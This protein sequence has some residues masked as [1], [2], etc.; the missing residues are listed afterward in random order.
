[1]NNF[2]ISSAGIGTALK[3]SAAAL[4]SANNTL[5]ES[6]ALITAGNTVVQNPEIIGTTAKTI[7]MFLR[8]SKTEAQEAGIETD[9]MAESVSKLRKEILALT[10]V[11]GGAGVD[12]MLDENTY[13]STYQILKEIAEVWD[14]I[15]DVSQA[16]ILEKLGGKRNAN[17]VASI[18]ENFDVA[19]EALRTS[20]DSIGSATEENEK[21]LNSIEGHLNKLKV[22]FEN[23]SQ[24]IINSDLV[25]GAIDFLTN[26]SGL[27]NDIVNNHGLWSIPTALAAS[28]FFNNGKFG[29]STAVDE[30]KT[31]FTILGKT[32]DQWKEL[33]TS[34]KADGG[35][36]LNTFG[37]ALG[38]RIKSLFGYT[39]KADIAMSKKQLTDFNQALVENA[40]QYGLSKSAALSFYQAQIQGNGIL[41]N[42]SDK[43]QSVAL[44]LAEAFSK[45]GELDEATEAGTNAIESF[46]TALSATTTSATIGRLAIN[47]LKEAF[48]SLAPMLIV[49]AISFIVTKVQQAAEEVEKLRAEAIAAS[50]EET[51]IIADV[52]TKLVE[53]N[54][55]Y[56]QSQITKSEY[57]N[58]TEKLVE[59]LHNEGIAVDN[60]INKYEDFGKVLSQD[61]ILKIKDNLPNLLERAQ[62]DVASLVEQITSIYDTKLLNPS[63]F[64]IS[65]K[66]TEVKSIVAA[67][68][69][70]TG[71]ADTSFGL[72]G[73]SII[74]IL[75]GKTL[76]STIA[77][78]N[79]YGVQ[80]DD[81]LIYNE[82]KQY[83]DDLTELRSRLYSAGETNSS[84]YKD[85]E[86]AITELSGVYGDAAK[87]TE[88]YNK[89]VATVL[90]GQYALNNEL[91]KTIE[92]Y[93]KYRSEIL[94][95][96]Y[97]NE[98]F[99]IT[100]ISGSQITDAILTAL[101]ADSSLAKWEQQYQNDQKT[102]ERLNTIYPRMLN[103]EAEK[104]KQYI[105]TLTPEDMGILLSLDDKDIQKG[106]TSVK[107]QIEKAHISL[108]LDLLNTN[109][110]I[111]LKEPL[112]DITK[113]QGKLKP[114]YAEIANQQGKVQL[115]L[116]QS[117]VL[118]DELGS[119]IFDEFE[120]ID[121]RIVLTSSDL[122]D[123]FDKFKRG[124]VENLYDLIKQVEQYLDTLDRAKESGL[125]TE[126]E[127]DKQ[128]L[129]YKQI[130]NTLQ[131]RQEYI[132]QIQLASSN[133]D[134]Y[135][136]VLEYTATL[137]QNL[138]H[139][140]LA[141]KLLGEF[142]ATD[143][144]IADFD[145]QA[146]EMIDA[147]ADN[148]EY[149]KQIQ[150][151]YQI[152][153]NDRSKANAQ[154][155]VDIWKEAYDADVNNFNEYQTIRSNILELYAKDDSAWNEFINANATFVQ[156]LKNQYD[157]DLTN[158]K[159]WAELRDEIIK[160]H[161]GIEIDKVQDESAKAA[162]RQA[163][164]NSVLSKEI[165]TRLRSFLGDSY[166]YEPKDDG[167]AKTDSTKQEKDT[168]DEK[169]KN[170]LKDLK[171][172]NKGTIENEKQF[173]KDWTALNEETYKTTDP[174]KYSENLKEISDYIES[175]DELVTK[176]LGK[177]DKVNSY[178]EN[179]IASR[180]VHLAEARRIN[181]NAYGDPNSLFY[182]LDT[183]EKNAADQ[184]KY[185]ADTL[186]L[187]F[188]RGLVDYQTF[189][190][191]IR[192]IRESA[193]D[194]DGNY[195]LD[196]TFVS[197]YEDRDK[198]FSEQLD[199]LQR[200]NDKSLDD[201]AEY[202]RQWKAL[203]DE[204]YKGTDIT[205]YE[206]NL[207]EIANYERD[208]LDRR[209][210]E[211]L[212][213]AEDYRASLI[214]LWED[215]NAILGEG[216]LNEWLSSAVDNEKAELDRLY[217]E[218]KISA[219]EYFDYVEALWEENQN[220]LGQR[221]QEEWLE[222][223]WK[224]RAE[225]EKTYWEQQKDLAT[226][227]YD[228]EL[229][230]LQDVKDEE[231]KISK[232]EELRLNLI[233]A[234][235]ALEDAKSQRNQLVFH[236]GTFEYM[237]DQEAVMSAQE[238]IA[239]ALKAIKDNE[240]EEQIK[241]LEEQKDEALL[242]YDNIITMLD[243]YINDTKQILT[244]DSEVLAHAEASE[245]G[246]YF[247]RLMNGEITM[248]EVKEEYKKK[249]IKDPDA[250]KKAEEKRTTMKEWG[251]ALLGMGS[252]TLEQL[253]L[254]LWQEAENASDIVGSI[255]MGAQDI[256]SSAVDNV[257]NNSN[258]NNDNSV[259]VGD[260]HMTIQGGTSVEM[261]HEFASKLGSAISE[262]A[263]RA[264][265]AI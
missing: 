35:N 33:H 121:G 11:N 71:K 138:S 238:E 186:K 101:N 148:A 203:N 139:Y 188:D 165:E 37:S 166:Q 88:Y 123:F 158:C 48:V 20:I 147:F 29:I 86:T 163:A 5:D 242:F 209:F 164:E 36:A 189:I 13:K 228:A 169:Y 10:K 98:N 55:S 173:I 58:E 145:K 180:I 117:A 109:G 254:D 136:N 249:Y 57:K 65:P 42:A 259:K 185:E 198:Q 97:Q 206:S 125:V 232:A 226:D 54:N 118:V 25:K 217:N 252:A 193:R 59:Q 70:E 21:Y 119:E 179:S 170:R 28:A 23:L 214:S 111:N 115:T 4:A 187:R 243:Y 104:L 219:K 144:W 85:L 7:S 19:E 208:L 131:A 69:N 30:G 92:E 78:N 17:V 263:P 132:D 250:E 223:A 247:R 75:S 3:K 51:D 205:K 43:V 74:D 202:V 152:W 129:E 256:A 215:N 56:A 181:Y 22:S 127:Y 199:M 113:L 216:V 100:D 192:R 99:Y 141:D 221:T 32:K 122:S 207:K 190:S 12:I 47:A 154:K 91:P 38:E 161:L 220:I 26:I 46:I 14:N 8:A 116:E 233:K 151:A 82:I 108:N 44:T 218:G 110:T 114:I 150:T 194:R 212:I 178:D 24:S 204:I 255:G 40:R 195:L 191:G 172:V 52:Y 251:K 213:S 140:N 66:D 261:L 197:G 106:I 96:A 171:R 135:N 41:S 87:S 157:L 143:K 211:G 245:S 93:R 200:F 27:L 229:K 81:A 177:W 149:G 95:E 76:A 34:I 67:W 18:I 84:F 9:G 107:S 264:I 156:E 167:S 31:L 126:E 257:Y 133:L 15:S 183:Y 176:T 231:E 49:E 153:L 236:N 182:N 265:A 160:S 105:K 237:A 155:F 61:L 184:A 222:D 210:K 134:K 253:T 77:S 201:E 53:V 225:T 227:Y 146:R 240:L 258:V 124:K 234:R 137:N 130:L 142:E 120:H 83:Y 68:V 224:K 162:I 230:K 262:L 239:E 72:N 63:Q 102:S 260:I 45:Y 196:M 73:N 80:I 241:L 89:Q 235:K 174:D 248:D 175:L 112:D 60:L 246:Q 6:I 39:S 244:S 94:S 103:E 168:T 62:N 16:N 2:A 128:K 1:M 159:N 90:V 50:K 64:A 79:L